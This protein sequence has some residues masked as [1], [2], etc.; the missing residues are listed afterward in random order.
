M[1]DILETIDSK[2][3]ETFYHYD[4]YP[5]DQNG[6]RFWRITAG[7]STQ[8]YFRKYIQKR[9]HDILS[10]IPQTPEEKLIKGNYKFNL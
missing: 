8:K 5:E 6:D 2:K 9:E 10:S 3:A 1:I 7:L 4:I